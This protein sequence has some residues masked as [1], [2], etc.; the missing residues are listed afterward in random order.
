MPGRTLTSLK[1][2]D[3]TKLGGVG[4]KKAESLAV[5]DPPIETVFDLLTHYPRRYLDR[6]NQAMIKDLKVGEE[7]MVLARVKRNQSRRTRQ[8]RALVELDVFDGSSYLK[9]TFFNQ[10]WR[11]RQLPVGTEAVFFGKLE[12]Y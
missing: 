9:C 2:I 5:M 6:T 11:G 10:G 7:A 3:V 4:P 8:G 12:V 1:E